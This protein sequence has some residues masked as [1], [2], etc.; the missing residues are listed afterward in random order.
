[1]IVL[2]IESTAHTFGVGIIKNKEILANCKDTFTT[3]SGGMIPSELTQHHEKVNQ[4]V[5]DDALKLAKTKVSD[6]NLISYSNA[7]GF[8]G[9]LSVGQVVA[10]NLSKKL[11]IPLVG[12]HHSVAHLE[13]GRMLFPDCTDPVLM[14][15]SGANTQVIAYEGNIY[16]VFGETLDQGI[17]NMID[18]F[19][20]YL[21][22]GFP[23]GPKIEKLAA[24]SNN[25]IELPYSVKGMDVNFGGI[26]TNLKHKFDS[27]KYKVEDLCFSLQETIFAML[28]E[29]T[30]R[31]MAHC[32]KDELLLGGGVACN[33][34]LKE[35]CQI[36]CEDRGAKC[37]IPPNSVLVDNGVMIAWLGRIMH[38]ADYESAPDKLDYYPY[39]RTDD[40]EVFWR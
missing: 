3:E 2:G 36:M 31:A 12:V 40:I 9:C 25:Y 28:V 29:V 8:G 16:R 34:R 20:R 6:I 35:M 17:G 4:K 1:M 15:A 37:F 38:E 39:Q 5:I 14:Y 23:G 21:G 33:S 7:P 27:K 24:K 30:E 26:L 19:A 32:D 10:R 22:L 18:S 13:I 11:N